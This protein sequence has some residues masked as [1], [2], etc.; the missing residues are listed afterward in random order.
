MWISGSPELLGMGL[1]CA[2]DRADTCEHPS[3]VWE[4]GKAPLGR[5]RPALGPGLSLCQTQTGKLGSEQ[6]NCLKSTGSQ[7]P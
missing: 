5:L 4:L 6:R 7:E 2:L 3:L 1:T